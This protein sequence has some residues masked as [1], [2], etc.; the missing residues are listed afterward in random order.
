MT[1]DLENFLNSL[2]LNN[3]LKLFK[4]NKIAMR[5]LLN[6]SDHDLKDVI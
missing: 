1:D 5:D 6:C 4:S 3:L 2:K